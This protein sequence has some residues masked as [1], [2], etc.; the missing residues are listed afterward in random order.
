MQA[1]CAA[2]SSGMTATASRLGDF[3]GTLVDGVVVVAAGVDRVE[4]AA[5][6]IDGV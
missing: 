3:N 5:A 6:K 2:V 1:K 4:G